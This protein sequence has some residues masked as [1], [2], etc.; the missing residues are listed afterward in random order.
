M[1]YK[2]IEEAKKE[3]NKPT[4]RFIR[5]EYGNIT[6]YMVSIE[7]DVISTIGKGKIVNGWKN[8]KGYKYTTLSINEEAKGYRVARLVAK[9]FVSN[10]NNKPHVDHI[11]GVR[12]HDN[13][14]NLRWC[15]NRENH[16]F[17]LA[18]ENHNKANKKT[19]KKGEYN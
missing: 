6:R 15:N 7:G 9:A 16:N 18:M 1:N 8:Y 13:Y 3:A 19:A 14:K 4:L 12:D 2:T 11:D 5:D 10:P 17:P